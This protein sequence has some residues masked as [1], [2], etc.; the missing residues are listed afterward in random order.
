V[1]ADKGLGPGEKKIRANV[2]EGKRFDAYSWHVRRKPVRN[3]E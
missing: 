2:D 1:S 3:R